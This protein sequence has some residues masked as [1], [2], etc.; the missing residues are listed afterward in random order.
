MLGEDID[1]LVE[2]GFFELERAAILHGA[3]EDSSQRIVAI[4]IPRLNSIRNR[5]RQRAQVVGDDAEGDVDLFLLGDGHDVALGVGLRQ[6]ALVGLRNAIYNSEAADLIEDRLENVGVVVAD[7]R[8]FEV[9]EVL[10]ALD[11]GADTLEAHAGIDVL[12]WEGNEGAIGVGVVLDE[13]VVPDL[14]AAGVAAVDELGSGALAVFVE[15]RGTGREVDVDLGARAAGAGVAH[16]PEV[17][18]LVAVD[19]V[20]VGIEAD[21][22]ELL[23][24]KIVGFLVAISRV[25]SAGLIN[26]G[27]DAGRRE[28]PLLDDQF[29]S[30]G[31]GFL[32]EVVAEGPVAEHL[33]ECVMVGVEADVFEVV[34]LAAGADALLRVR[35]AR[36]QSFVQHAG[37]GIHI[38]AALA[39][40]DGHELVHTRVREDARAV[41]AG[42]ADVVTGDDGVVLRF[43]EVEEGL[44]DLG[45]GHHGK[46]REV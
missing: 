6:R 35:R 14:D 40:E 18:L 33:E 30:P 4:R 5:E 45:G 2:E 44:A 12:G 3:A 16:H 31:D 20:D 46:G 1:E 42:V 39:E 24:P 32:L 10:R 15:V 25:A 26:G 17:V 11:D 43:E 36:W 8:V 41:A 21:A 28:L 9:G 34:V 13:D 37:P 23:G 22:A 19:D 27:E 7:L 38:R 29:P